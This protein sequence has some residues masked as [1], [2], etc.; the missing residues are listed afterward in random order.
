MRDVGALAHADDEGVVAAGTVLVSSVWGSN[1]TNVN[2]TLF[3]TGDNGT[4]GTELWKSDGTAAGTTLVKDI[5]PGAYQGAPSSLA[6]VGG[7][8]YFSAAD[9]TTSSADCDTALA[10]ATVSAA[11]CSRLPRS[12]STL[13]R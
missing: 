9:D 8:L 11:S 13:E 1:L 6:D 7:V 3:F 2:G 12:D 10:A 5:Y 4:S